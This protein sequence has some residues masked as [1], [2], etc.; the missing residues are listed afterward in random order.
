MLSDIVKLP[1]LMTLGRLLL[2]IPVAI[3]LSRPGP[4]YRIY[5]LLCLA[6]AT[7]TDY[8][9]GYLARKLNQQ[10][11][12]GLI[13][14]PL[15]DK[16][17]A[18]VLVVMLI[19]YRAFPLWLAVVVIGRDLLIVLGSFLIHRKIQD[20]PSSNFTGKYAFA[21]I[22]FLLVAYVLDNLCAIM[23]SLPVAGI[24]IA[25][26]LAV[27][28]HRLIHVMRG[29]PMP[30]FDDRPI[31]RFTRGLGATIYLLIFLYCVIFMT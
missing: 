6:A 10:T 7:M 16:F 3:F 29:Q 22:A 9:D 23:I 15:S 28:T 19:V 26:S 5:T 18:L 13:L 30:R 11:R 31:F 4:E 1:N 27:Y 8:F 24:F 2:L 21:S 14:D 12:L 20:I 17:L 25:L